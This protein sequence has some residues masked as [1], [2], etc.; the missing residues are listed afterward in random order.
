MPTWIISGVSGAG[1]SELAQALARRLNAAYLDADSFHPPANIEKMQ[2]QRPLDEADREVWLQ[3]I[4]TALRAHAGEPL[5][6]AFPGLKL[7][8]RRRVQAAAA[9]ARFAFLEVDLATAQ[10]RLRRRGGFFPPALAA[11]QFE[12]LERDSEAFVLDGCL[13]PAELLYQALAWA[14]ARPGGV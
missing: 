9:D 5:V 13:D 7:A 1:K 3:G 11:S 2:A 8:H 6:L 10:L 14:K 4:E 12:A